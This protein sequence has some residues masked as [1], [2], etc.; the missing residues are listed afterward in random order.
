MSENLSK[1]SCKIPNFLNLLL[2]TYQLIFFNLYSDKI[3][4]S[5]S[6]EYKIYMDK[7]QNLTKPKIITERLSLS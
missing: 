2:T 5:K 1:Q 7:L 4:K 3:Q 6:S